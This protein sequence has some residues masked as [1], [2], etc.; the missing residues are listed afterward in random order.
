MTHRER[1]LAAC[2]GEVPDRVPW[3]PRLDLWYAAHSRSDTLPREFRG[4]TLRE[5]TDALG[6]GYHAVIPDFS[7]VLSTDGGA[8]RGL[9]IYHLKGMAYDTRL[10][11]VKREVA[12]Q[13]AT[14]RITYHTPVGSVSCAF[15]FTEEMR[16][17]GASISWM[18]EHLLKQPA[19]Y[20]VLEHIFSHLKVVPTHE[21]YRA[22]RDW[23]GEAGVAVAYGNAAASPM[24]HIM[25]DLMP[26]TDFFLELHDHPERL[27]SLAR[28]MVPWLAQVLSVLVRSPAEVILWGGNYDATI[29]YP[30]FFEEH[31]LP[32]LTR[33]A[34]AAH[35]HDKL[36]LTHTDGENAGLLPLYRQAGF[37]IADSLC[38]APMTKLTLAQAIAALPGVTI[39]GGIPSLALIKESASDRDFERLIADTMTLATGRSHLILGIADTT[40][41]NASFDR[42]RH[43]TEAAA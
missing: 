18:D 36:L 17:A 12:V 29:T 8:D 1:I 9:G 41:A 21:R 20:Q 32:W 43:I 39:W 16:Q 13:G 26:M 15:R 22:W 25:R 27:R 40:P 30:P 7:D 37:D 24:Q 3:V 2:R 14:T 11:D 4:M 10:R 28:S 6:V 38:P 19:D 5:I 23:V 42:L 34:E 33:A 35:A 31:I